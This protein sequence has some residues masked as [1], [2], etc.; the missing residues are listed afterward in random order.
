VVRGRNASEYLVQ[1]FDGPRSLVATVSAFLLEGWNRG[2][3]L[4]V[5]ARSTHWPLLSDALEA[6]GCP[7][8][9]AMESGRIVALDAE[10]TLPTFMVHGDPDPEKFNAVVGDLVRRLCADLPEGLTIYGEMVDVLVGQGNFAAADQLEGLWST[11]SAHCSFRLLC[12]YSA[13]HFNDAGNVEKLDAIT[14]SH[15]RADMSPADVLAQWL[16]AHRR[17]KYGQ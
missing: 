4:L 2:D 7:A 17:P 11:L 12:G 6:A 8:R 9:S 15:T 1:L 16:L 13:R 3:R 14:G 5:L 10:A